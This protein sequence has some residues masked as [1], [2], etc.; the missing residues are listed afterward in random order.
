MILQHQLDTQERCGP[1]S[2]IGKPSIVLLQA[3][4]RMTKQV[5]NGLREPEVGLEPVQSL[6]YVTVL[7]CK[8]GSKG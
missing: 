3:L 4:V 6:C 1:I 7:E 8:S 5:Q 2:T